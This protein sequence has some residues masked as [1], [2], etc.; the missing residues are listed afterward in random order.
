M[1]ED[2]LLNLPFDPYLFYKPTDL[3]FVKI[4]DIKSNTKSENS[5][6]SILFFPINSLNLSREEQKV[7]ALPIQS[8]FRSIYIDDLVKKREVLKNELSKSNYLKLLRINK[9]FDD[10]ISK[11]NSSLSGEPSKFLESITDYH[12]N[13]DLAI[14]CCK[15]LRTCNIIHFV[16]FFNLTPPKNAFRTLARLLYNYNDWIAVRSG[17]SKCKRYLS[18]MILNSSVNYNYEYRW[19]HL[20]STLEIITLL[21]RIDNN[22]YLNPPN[23][24][25][26]NQF[27]P[28]DTYNLTCVI[29]EYPGSMAYTVF[30]MIL[31]QIA[32][33]NKWKINKIKF[34]EKI[35]QL[36]I[37]DEKAL[38]GLASFYNIPIEQIELTFSPKNWCFSI[39]EFYISSNNTKY[40]IILRFLI[41]G[42]NTY[43]Y[44]FTIISQDLKAL[45]HV[46]YRIKKNEIIDDMWISYS[47]IYKTNLV[48]MKQ[49]C[50]ITGSTL[51]YKEKEDV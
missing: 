24:N 17:K 16:N 2:F 35:E 27:Y 34:S 9:M 50:D 3:K 18:P 32:E 7:I 1:K 28:N 4:T 42:Y 23:Y 29:N 40:P 20:P 6:P 51:D 26:F 5:V 37:G 30:F 45:K 49:A 10:E 21:A 15:H 8:I 38:F 25:I 31:L 12:I 44:S 11:V 48:T 14:E 13:K 47:N 33:Q 43:G 19:N 36:K 46:Y 41:P 39:F 22:F